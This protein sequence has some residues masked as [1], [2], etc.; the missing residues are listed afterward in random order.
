MTNERKLINCR[1][2][3]PRQKSDVNLSHIKAWVHSSSR[4]PDFGFCDYFTTNRQQGG[5]ANGEGEVTAKTRLFFQARFPLYFIASF[6]DEDA[7]E[8]L[9]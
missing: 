4:V 9:V 7:I 1:P 5:V 6:R 3:K 2:G 8:N